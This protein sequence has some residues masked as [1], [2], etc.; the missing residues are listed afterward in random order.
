MP[1]LILAE[2]S[3]GFRGGFRDGWKTQETLVMDSG[4]N[5][6]FSR[7]IVDFFLVVVVVVSG[8]GD[9]VTCRF[10]TCNQMNKWADGPS[11]R[12]LRWPHVQ[13]LPLAESQGLSL[14]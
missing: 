14:T 5:P 10:L 11:R 8:L 12:P 1:L 13:R 6:M 3:G 2:F 9:C 7:T 4:S